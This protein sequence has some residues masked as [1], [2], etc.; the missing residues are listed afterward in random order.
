MP[1]VP[2]EIISDVDSLYAEAVERFQLY[3]PDWEP[4]ETTVVAILLGASAV[5]AWEQSYAM[6]QQFDNIYIDFGEELYGIPP[7]AA[8]NAEAAT[9][10]VA[11]DTDGHTIPAGEEI[12]IDGV[13][14]QVVSAVTIPPGSTSTAVG[15]VLVRALETGTDANGLSAP[16]EP[17][18]SLEAWLESIAVVGTTSGGSVGETSA[19]YRARLA[20]ELTTVSPTAVTAADFVKFARRVPGAYRAMVLDGFLPG[21][22]NVLDPLTGSYGNSGHIT[23]STI[24]EEGQP[25]PEDD[26]VADLEARRIVGIDVHYIEPTYNEIDVTA[27]ISVDTV[28]FVALDVIAQVEAAI[29]SYLS[30]SAWGLPNY[31]DA[32]EREWQ[33]DLYVRRDEVFTVINNVPGVQHVDTL[34]IDGNTTGN[35]LLT[36]D[37]PLP[38]PGSIV[39]TE[40]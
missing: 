29:E 12:T 28:H 7:L 17:V 36:G 19:E 32:D 40:T 37:I 13:G 15:E 2:P 8:T 11:A 20:D 26:V 39:V 35:V 6:A 27:E 25:G 30:A 18:S 14:F 33:R 4:D 3:Y 24:D 9:T 5:M 34:N 22:T 38:E 31:A 1:Y 23:V 21:G 16:V 10:W